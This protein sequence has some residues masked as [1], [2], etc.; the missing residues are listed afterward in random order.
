MGKLSKALVSLFVL[1]LSLGLAGCGGDDAFQT[2]GGTT[3]GGDTGS[4]QVASIILLAS[5][6]N[7]GSADTSTVT[8]TAQVKNSNNALM[9]GE[10]VIFSASGGGLLVDSNTTNASG[11]ATATLS[12]AGDPTNRS[13]TVSATAGGLTDTVVVNVTGTTVSVSGESSV[14]FGDSITLTVFVKDSDN[15]GVPGETVSVQSAS[16]NTL[17]AATLTTGTSGD[18]QITLTGS[19][20]GTD[21]IT[22]SALNATATYSVDVSSDEFSV[23]L[24]SGDLDI[25]TP[26]TIT[27]TWN[28]NGSPVTDGK[29]VNFSATRGTLSSST[30][31]T[32]GGTASVTVSSDTAG[33]VLVTAFVTNGPSASDSA[34][35]VATTPATINVQAAA[36]TMGPDGQENVIT[37]VVRDANGNLVKNQSIR[38]TIEADESG[39]SISNSTDI[40]DALGRAST[41]Y[42]STAATTAKDGVVI[43][44][45]IQGTA[46]SDTVAITVAKTSLFVRLGTSHLL[47]SV[48]DTRYKKQYSVLVTDAGGNAA[49]NTDVVI[50][51]IPITYYKGYRVPTV[52]DSGQ[53]VAPMV[54]FVTA[55]CVNEDM[56]VPGTDLNGVLDAGEDLN[57]NGALEPGNIASVPGT[58]TTD[59]TGFGII[60]I[61]YAKDYADWVDVRLRASAQVAGSEGFHE[62]ELNLP[63]LAS[64]VDT[65][66][67]AVPGEV[68]PFGD[69]YNT[70]TSTWTNTCTD[71]H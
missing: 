11:I 69:G 27:A 20:G 18:A 64:D 14:V 4:S 44:A 10:S 37:A 25:G 16:G 13:I 50:T 56:L 24:P 22:V 19:V 21:T 47:Q 57:S 53:D 58:V 43:R 2:P 1:V 42:T 59:E 65:L 7:L 15:N 61:V 8:L 12:T 49:A 45:E 33:P 66:T 60:D 51:L 5:S 29:T 35:F 46:L 52:N 48:D 3:D 17:S 31:T 34:D 54:P 36:E 40:T 71:A 26:H 9:E 63:V 23:A 67:A 6:P 55:T 38:F 32:S 28:Q 70:E 30:A 62:V 68:S 41:K 39:G